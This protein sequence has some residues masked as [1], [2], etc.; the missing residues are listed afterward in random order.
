MVELCREG[1]LDDQVALPLEADLLLVAVPK[2]HMVILVFDLAHVASDDVVYYRV[3]VDRGINDE[4]LGPL[5]MASVLALE[6]GDGVRL[7]EVQGCLLEAELGLV[8]DEADLLAEL[9]FTA[10]LKEVLVGHL[11]LHH[12]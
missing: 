1:R 8:V 11:L 4:V 7:L 6:V 5:E 3:F 10:V 12:D 9:H 2:R